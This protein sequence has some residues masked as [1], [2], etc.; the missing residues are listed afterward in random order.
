MNSRNR[1]FLIIL[2]KP[3][4]WYEKSWKKKT[5]RNSSLFP[6]NHLN[7][8]NFCAFRRCLPKMAKLIPAKYSILLKLR[9]L[10]PA[11]KKRR[12]KYKFLGI[13]LTPIYRVPRLRIG[14][15]PSDM[16]V[17]CEYGNKQSRTKPRV[18]FGKV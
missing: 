7:G 10:I 3:P 4:S 8:T 18:A 12:K 1:I 14:E 6:W 13:F 16:E 9:K 2:Y 11:R 15:R 17:S 5:N